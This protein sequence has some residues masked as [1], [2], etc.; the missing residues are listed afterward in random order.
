MQRI[1]DEIHINGEEASGGITHHGVRYVL[2]I[3]LALVVLVM[4]AVWIT[5][6]LNS[7]PPQ[8]SDTAT[9]EEAALA[10]G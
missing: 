6:A 8:A 1:G 4:S 10:S 5:G 2:A 7:G 9:A 3:S